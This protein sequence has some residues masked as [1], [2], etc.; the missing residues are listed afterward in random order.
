LGKRLKERRISQAMLA[1]NLGVSENT[2][3]GWTTGQHS[4]KAKVLPEIARELETSVGELFG[5]KPPT[6]SAEAGGISPDS[7]TL[8]LVSRL[9]SL[10]LVEQLEALGS[11]VP[12]LLEILKRAEQLG[13]Q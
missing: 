3:S 13:E 7:I 2:V 1:K 11:V 5:E 10:R 6:T 8:D 4:P 12:E 9:A